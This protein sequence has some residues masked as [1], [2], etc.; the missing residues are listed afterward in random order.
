MASVACARVGHGHGE[1]CPGVLTHDVAMVEPGQVEG[2]CAMRWR[3][4]AARRRG[5][6]VPKGF[7]EVVVRGTGLMG[8]CSK[9][10][11]PRAADTEKERG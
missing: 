5:R 1:R 2:D 7:V 9:R 4:E 11:P 6:A 8:S 3:V 10:P